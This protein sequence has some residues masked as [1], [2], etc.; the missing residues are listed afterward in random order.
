MDWMYL[1]PVTQ[2]TSLSVEESI[3]TCVVES[4]RTSGGHL[5]YFMGIY[6][7]GYTSVDQPYFSGVAVMRRTPRDRQHIWTFAVGNV[8]NHQYSTYSDANIPIPY[9]GE[10]YFCVYRVSHQSSDT[11]NSRTVLYKN[12]A[13]NPITVCISV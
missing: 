5:V 6:N 11:I 10:D 8:E 9:V 2:C 7:H 3:V 4:K 12:E 13:T 1:A